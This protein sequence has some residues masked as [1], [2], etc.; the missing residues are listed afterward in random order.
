MLTRVLQI[1]GVLLAIGA[2]AAPMAFAVFGGS[3]SQPIA[4]NHKLHVEDNGLECVEC[5]IYVMTQPF[6]GYPG[7][8]KCLECHE[9]AQTDSAEEEKIRQTAAA[10]EELVWNRIYDVPDHVYSSH[11]RHVVAGELECAECHGPIA[12]ATSPPSRPLND[13][14]MDFCM[15]CHEQ[16]G[17]TNDCIA[18]HM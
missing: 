12:D 9:E 14:S 10:G 2:G 1:S 16:R 8:D 7:V 15:D 18:C 11:R 5:H 4:F 13:L 17:V 3:I 6:A